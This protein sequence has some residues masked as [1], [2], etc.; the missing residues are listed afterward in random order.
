LRELGFTD[1]GVLMNKNEKDEVEPLN[2]EEKLDPV[3][4][5]SVIR[6]NLSGVRFSSG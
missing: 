4:N 6:F 1:F 3:I 5:G 2:G